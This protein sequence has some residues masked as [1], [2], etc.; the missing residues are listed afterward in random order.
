MYAGGGLEKEGRL[1]LAGGLMM[2]VPTLVVEWIGWFVSARLETKSW[3]SGKRGGCRTCS[4]YE[5]ASRSVA[6]DE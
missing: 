4:I 1:V 6:A 5:V 3:G 2:M